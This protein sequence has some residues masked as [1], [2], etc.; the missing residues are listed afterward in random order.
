[1]KNKSN[2]NTQIYMKKFKQEKLLQ[3]EEK[4]IHYVEN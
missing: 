3:V 4:K 1:M 2:K